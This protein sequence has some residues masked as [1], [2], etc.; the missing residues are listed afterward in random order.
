MLQY[1][2]DFNGKTL[3]PFN[4]VM[5][6]FLPTSDKPITYQRSGAVNSREETGVAASLFRIGHPFLNSLYDYF[7][8]DDRG[9]TYAIWRQSETWNALGG[10]D[11]LFFRFEFVVEA[12]VQTESASAN[13]AGRQAALQRR[14]DALFAPRFETV[15]T[16][17]NGVEVANEKL[18]E[19]VKAKP[20][21]VQDGGMDTNVKGDRLHL[22]DRFIDP[23]DWGDHCQN[24][25]E[26]AEEAFVNREDLVQQCLKAQERAEKDSQERIQRLRLRAAKEYSVGDQ[27]EAYR[28]QLQREEHVADVLQRGIEEPSIRLDSVGVI[29]ISGSKIPS[30][31]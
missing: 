11:R 31:Q 9:R 2:P 18:E 17:R 28:N 27:E 30:S 21:R 1:Q 22:L 8:W 4:T 23:L 29:I 20:H 24:A 25:R 3:I 19:I 15:V 6:R 12:D 7:R 10:E 5:N 26:A 16:D 13:D 14:A